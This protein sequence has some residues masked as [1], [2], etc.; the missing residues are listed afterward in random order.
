M[1]YVI[2]ILAVFLILP[3]C[4]RKEEAARK[5]KTRAEESITKAIAR[6]DKINDTLSVFVQQVA[7]SAGESLEDAKF[8]QNL[9]SKLE[10]Y[11]KYLG[12][13]KCE[14]KSLALVDK[15]CRKEISKLQEVISK[16][17]EKISFLNKEVAETQIKLEKRESQIAR[18]L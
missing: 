16:G 1:K 3:G 13:C 8:R 14:L 6:I 18:A 15:D 11:A 12:G 2:L 7:S 9:Q 5:E 10:I 17:E 4:G